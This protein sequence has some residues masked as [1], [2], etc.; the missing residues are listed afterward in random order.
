[1]KGINVR[2][3]TSAG[4]I[5]FPLKFPIVVPTKQDPNEA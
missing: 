5:T 1:M 4:G 2:T 3:Y